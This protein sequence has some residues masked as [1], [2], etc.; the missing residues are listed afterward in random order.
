MYYDEQR[1][2]GDLE[3]NKNIFE[4]WSDPESPPSINAEPTKAGYTPASTTTK[5]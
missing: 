2:I 5:Q 1:G 3:I 4:T